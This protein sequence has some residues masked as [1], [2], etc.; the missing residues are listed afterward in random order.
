MFTSYYFRSHY[1]GSYYFVNELYALIPCVGGSVSLVKCTKANTQALILEKNK[2]LSSI[3]TLENTTNIPI[4]GGAIGIK[5]GN[6][7][8]DTS[9]S[10]KYIEFQKAIA[11]L[12]AATLI[13]RNCDH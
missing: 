12:K 5:M 9:Q 6:C 13:N 1:F 3:N 8:L 11:K 10:K 7:E 2:I 4:N